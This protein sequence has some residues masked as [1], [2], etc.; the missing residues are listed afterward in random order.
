MIK[1]I[2][3]ILK[4]I[5]VKFNAQKLKKINDFLF[6]FIEKIVV[7]LDKLIYIYLDF[8]KPIVI[9]ELKF[10]DISNKKNIL[11][12]GSG[13]I[14]ATSILISNKTNSKI[15]CLDK[16]LKSIK[17][18]KVLL[19]KIK[20]NKQITVI[21]S[22]LK[23]I[24]FSLYDLII[25]SQGVEPYLKILKDISKQMKKDTKIIFRTSLDSK[26]KI[27]NQDIILK[28]YFIFKN[29]VPQKKNALLVSLILEKK[30]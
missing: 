9:N 2:E 30:I 21:F 14:P 7:K 6:I 19:S 10:L 11:H 18:A 17:Q 20:K 23:D 13:P 24:Q 12:I 26:G 4:K 22:D 8:Y 1:V 15:T 27:S 16:N 3:Y 28:K 5:V 29:I 25:V